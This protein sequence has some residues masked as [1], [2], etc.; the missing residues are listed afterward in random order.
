MSREPHWQAKKKYISQRM[1]KRRLNNG[2]TENKEKVCSN[3]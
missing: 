3:N 2:N 1:K